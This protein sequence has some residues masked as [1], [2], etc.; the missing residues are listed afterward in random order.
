MVIRTQRRLWTGWA[1]GAVSLATVLALAIFF[2]LGREVDIDVYLLGGK[3][4]FGSHLYDIPL[5]GTGLRFTYPPFA[6]LVFAPMALLPTVVAQVLWSCLNVATLAAL[7]FA[8]IRATR[9]QG[10]RSTALRWALVL[11]LPA[12]ALDPVH[13]TL[14]FGQ[15]NLIVTLLVLADL[16]GERH[17]GAL[18]LPRGV[19]IGIAAAVKLT[20]LVFLPYL[21]LT[22]QAR[23]GR[24]AAVTFLVCSALTAV[25]APRAGWTFW[26]DDVF[27]SRSGPAWFISDQNLRGFAIRL[28]HGPVPGA[29][30]WGVTFGVWVLGMAVA[31]AAYRRSSPL[32]GALVCAATGL[33]I[34]PIT[35]AHHLVWVVP[36]LLWLVLAA[37]RPVRGLPLAVAGWVM[38]TLRLIWWAPNGNNHELAE[39]GWQL[40]LGNSY[41]FSV[42]LFIVATGALLV[43]RARRPTPPAAALLCERTGPASHDRAARQ[44]VPR[45]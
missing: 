4:V 18:R 8:G 26:T 19:L 11:V 40:V 38:F 43:L 33:L 44:P 39:H 25:V 9:P 12:A 21:F 13:L 16:T 41:F 35:W 28:H 30:L 45:I 17:V 31:V 1:A 24:N 14:S 27:R 15:V 20:P 32:L 6:A 5:P 3:H 22:R 7:L 10:E 36:V 23:A 2:A 37:D 29:V 42:C 34:S